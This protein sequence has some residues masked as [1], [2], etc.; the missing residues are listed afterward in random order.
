MTL[1]PNDLEHSQRVR[2]RFSQQMEWLSEHGFRWN[3]GLVLNYVK[4]SL[5]NSNRLMANQRGGEAEKVIGSLGHTLRLTP[6]IKSWAE[7]SRELEVRGAYDYS[8]ALRAHLWGEFRT[9]L[10]Y[11]QMLSNWRAFLVSHPECGM[12]FIKGYRKFLDDTRAFV[13]EQ[14]QA[15]APTDAL[16]EL[17][18]KL[19]EEWH[20]LPFRIRAKRRVDY[21]KGIAR[22]FRARMQAVG[23]RKP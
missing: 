16:P 8:V 9:I 3:F 4:R 20:G 13:L 17:K 14:E 23:A 19:R 5:N 6:E 22:R 15:D 10:E 11:L 21:V 7:K 18:D 2:G 12:L 1:N